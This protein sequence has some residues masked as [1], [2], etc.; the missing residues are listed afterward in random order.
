M[1]LHWGGLDLETSGS[2]HTIDGMRYFAEVGAARG[3]T[4]GSGPP[5]MGNCIPQSLQG[6][7]GA[8][9]PTRALVGAVGGLSLSTGGSKKSHGKSTRVLQRGSCSPTVSTKLLNQRCL[10]PGMG[11]KQHELG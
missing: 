11:H 3:C 4:E 1:H 5:T 6:N 9:A 10:W 7:G 2:E 8:R